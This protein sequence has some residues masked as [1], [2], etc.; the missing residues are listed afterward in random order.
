M[1]T[2]RIA[3]SLI[4]IAMVVTACTNAGTT[5]TSLAAA[6]ASTLAAP[7]Q[8]APL[9]DPDPTGSSTTVLP[10]TTTA[11]PT[12]PPT[13]VPTTTVPTTTVP[14]PDPIKRDRI[15]VITPQPG[16]LAESPL[17]I[18]GESMT[19]DGNV[20]YRLMAGGMVIAQGLTTGGSNGVWA[21][22]SVAV[23]FT[24]ECCIEMLLEVYEAAPVP[25][26]ELFIVR[27]P[28]SYSE[29]S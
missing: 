20:H 14:I 17:L 5:D 22:F 27:I 8:Q 6:P 9:V 26:G 10:T 19:G 11:N 25:G 13:S 2:S 23:D 12:V 4:V 29:D 7:G 21:P 18:T 3:L 28:L 24:N 1:S 16:D 15:E